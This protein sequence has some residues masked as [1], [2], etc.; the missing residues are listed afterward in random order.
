[1]LVIKMP[2][3]LKQY[4][5]S[6]K[7]ERKINSYKVSLSKEIVEQTGLQDKEIIIKQDGDRIIIE[8]DKK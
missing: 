4:Y 8:V 6:S 5:Y 3:L 7:G 1:M 2:K